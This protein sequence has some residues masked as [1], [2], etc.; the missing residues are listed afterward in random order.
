MWEGT[1][2]EKRYAGGAINTPGNS[3]PENNP[4][5]YTNIGAGET[6]TPGRVGEAY[7]ET[8]IEQTRTV[9]V[10]LSSLVCYKVV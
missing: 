3:V 10:R 8:R 6:P 7:H 2:Q 9:F 1:G 4:D 5:D